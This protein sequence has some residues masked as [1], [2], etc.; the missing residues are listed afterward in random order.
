MTTGLIDASLDVVAGIDVWDKAISTYKNNHDHLPICKDLTQYPP[1]EFTKETGIKSFDIL[2]GGPPCQGFY[3][4][5]KRK[6]NDPGNSL[7]KE[8][9]K[10]LNHF[11]PKAF[12]M[13]NV[14]G[15]LSMKTS[16][17]ELVK[18]RIITEL[19]KCYSWQ[20]YK[21]SAADFEVPQ[22][23]KRV[24][25]IGFRKDLNIQPTEPEK[26]S[27]THLAVKSVLEKKGCG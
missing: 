15:I 10:Y 13:E 7:S 25:I 6:E 27:T 24:T 11:K 9:V 18:E 8:Y 16:S 4:A 19:S 5:G 14:V 22:I 21:L 12:I 20:I 17:G 3:L 1:A 23:R 2:V 26:I